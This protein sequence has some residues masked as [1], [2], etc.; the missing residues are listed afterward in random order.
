MSRNSPR[1]SAERPL[2]AASTTCI[3]CGAALSRPGAPFCPVC[4]RS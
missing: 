1:P 3:H 2:V 4:G